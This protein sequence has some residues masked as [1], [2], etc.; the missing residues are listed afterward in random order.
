VAERG[1]ALAGYLIATVTSPYAEI[2]NLA[3]AP[4]QQRCGVAGRLLDDLVE[5]CRA[6][7][8]TELGLEVRVSNAAAQALYRTRG[9]RMTG[10]RRGYYRSPEEDAL[11]MGMRVR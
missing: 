10:L 7:G 1:G 8:V 11:L 9:F 2:Q 3:T 6:R 5:T 4:E